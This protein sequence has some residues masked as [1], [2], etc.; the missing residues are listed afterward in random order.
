MGRGVQPTKADFRHQS[1][2]SLYLK[3]AV[4]EP[5]WARQEAAGEVF[6]HGT[7]HDPL[8][9]EPTGSLAHGDPNARVASEADPE[10]PARLLPPPSALVGQGATRGAGGAR[11]RGHFNYFGVRGNE[12]RLDLLVESVKRSWF[13]WL[14]RRSQRSTLNWPRFVALLGDHPGCT[15]GSARDGPAFGGVLARHPVADGA[16]TR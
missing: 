6:V 2:V 3:T 13:K 1:K 10:G 15:R 11:I 12:R 9:A 5:K 8:E 4:S 7:F 16:R 14:N